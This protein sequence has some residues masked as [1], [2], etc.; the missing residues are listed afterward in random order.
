MLRDRFCVVSNA[1]VVGAA[2]LVDDEDAGDA[3]TIGYGGER[4]LPLA[5]RSDEDARLAVVDDVGDLFRREERIDAGVVQAG[6]LT[7]GAGFQ[8]ALVVLHE[9]GDVITGAE[10]LR[11]QEMR[12]SV[13]TGLVFAVADRRTRRRHDH[14]RPIRVPNGVRSWIHMRSPVFLVRTLHTC[15]RHR[16]SRGCTRQVCPLPVEASQRTG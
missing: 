9:N 11:A 1:V 13:C 5:S 3:G 4:C 15:L 14:C 8:I 6:A 10:A 12:Q 2:R 16:P 7:A